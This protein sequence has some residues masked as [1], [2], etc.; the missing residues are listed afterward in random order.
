MKYKSKKMKAWAVCFRLNKKC[1]S[2]SIVAFNKKKNAKG[3]ITDLH[4]RIR[5]FEADHHI[6][7]CEI[8]YKVK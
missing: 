6:I 5:G 7:P 4:E 8:N 2:G 3:Y 1:M